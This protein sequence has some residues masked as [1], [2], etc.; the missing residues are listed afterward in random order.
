MSAELALTLF[1]PSGAST[2]DGTHSCVINRNVV[3]PFA[4]E[5]GLLNLLLFLPIGF[6]G[7]MALRSLLPV[8]A[9][10]VLLSLATELLQTLL[11]WV[12]RGCDSSDLEMN[13]LGGI[14]GAL[15]AWALLRLR[16]RPVTP[17]EQHARA[18]ALTSAVLLVVA[19]VAWTLWIT[20]TAVDATSLQLT[21]N[22]ER[23]VAQ[24]A[25]HQAFGDRYTI[26]N[27]QLQP[28][29]DDAPDNLLI[30]LDSGSAELSW[31]DASQLNVSLE[32]SS[33]TTSASFPVPD[34]THTPAGE[35]DALSIAHRYADEHYPRELK[36][37]EPQVY[38]VGDRAELGWIVSWRRRGSNGVLMPMR[39][40]VQ[41]N[42][43]GRVSQ[44]LVRSADDPQN[45][46]PVKVDKE[47]A[48]RAA[49]DSMELPKGAHNVRATESELLAVQRD[50]QWRAQWMT[51]FEADDKSVI[52]DPVY[53]DANSGKVDPRASRKQKIDTPDSEEDGAVETT[54]N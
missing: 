48:Q 31:P 42:T 24:K 13:S 53:V 18:T 52:L 15:L 27:V 35:K 50:G 4:T 41:V 7:L 3:E 49:L 37:A 51:A 20:P 36:D 39:L 40:D 10:S 17:L 25:I 45:L 29:V 26:S 2:D 9:G 22:K 30:A 12:H 21:G 47:S 38:P 5:Q 8:L 46:P 34:V 33:E 14:A 1:L 16:R 54:V 43:A 23:R 32:S 19:G 28:G 44:L 6:F 11:P